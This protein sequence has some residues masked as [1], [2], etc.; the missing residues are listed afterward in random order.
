AEDRRRSRP[1]DRDLPRRRAR[2]NAPL[3]ARARRARDGSRR[4]ADPR[5]A[6]FGRRGG[7]LASGHSVDVAALHRLTGGNPFFVT[8]VLAAGGA[9][10]PE[11]VRDAVLA[12][13]AQLGPSARAAVEAVAI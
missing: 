2:P 13:V 7:Q 11:T 3:A 6:T 8:E 5:R 4:R 9:A 12:R 10:I 1:R